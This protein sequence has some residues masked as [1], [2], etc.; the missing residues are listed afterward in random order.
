VQ[1]LL[2]VAPAPIDVPATVRAEQE[3]DILVQCAHHSNSHIRLIGVTPCS[4]DRIRATAHADIVHLA[5][6]AT[7]QAVELEDDGGSA[8]VIGSIEAASALASPGPRLL[9]LNGCDTLELGH[10][11]KE[12]LHDAHV[13][14]C[15]GFLPDQVAELFTQTFYTALL[16]G[17]PVPSCVQ[18]AKA[19]IESRLQFTGFLYLEG[20]EWR[21]SG[22]VGTIHDSFVRARS[23]LA[24]ARILG[25]GEA[26]RTISSEIATGERSQ[27]VVVGPPRSGVTS[28]I[29]AA[30]V[31]YGHNFQAVQ[32]ASRPVIGVPAA[33]ARALVVVDDAHL[34]D[35][36]ELSELLGRYRQQQSRSVILVGSHWPIR[37]EGPRVLC[38]ESIDPA[39]SRSI[40]EREL[41]LREDT[42]SLITNEAPPLPGYVKAIGL[43]LARGESADTALGGVLAEMRGDVRSLLER[44]RARDVSSYAYDALA[45]LGPTLPVDLWDYICESAA[46]ASGE[47]LTMFQAAGLVSIHETDH[48]RRHILLIS[49]LGSEPA[50]ETAL[51]VVRRSL[52]FAESH[53]NELRVTRDGDWLAKL[54]RVGSRIGEGQRVARLA[55]RLLAP[56]SPFR[57]AGSGALA[58]P[59][60]EAGFAAARALGEVELIAQL[61]LVLG[62]SLY[63]A[64]DVDGANAV[65][66]QCADLELAPP[67]AIRVL[68]A[69]GQVQY[70]RGDFIGAVQLYDR[71]EAHR[72]D[73]P[74]EYGVTLDSQ[75]AKAMRRLGDVDGAL[76]LQQQ[77][78]RFYR[79]QGEPHA[80]AKAQHEMARTLAEVGRLAE[81]EQAFQAAVLTAE[82]EA[83]DRFLP[84]PLYELCKLKLAS[85]EIDDAAAFAARL[86]AKAPRSGDPL[87][88]AYARFAEGR[89]AFARRR[90]DRSRQAVAEA[91]RVADLGGYVQV[92]ADVLKWL[93]LASAEHP[94]VA[95]ALSQTDI[96]AIAELTGLPATKA[97]KAWAYALD[98]QRVTKIVATFRS[99]SAVRT[100]ALEHGAWRCDCELF[101]THGNCS[102]VAAMRLG[103]LG[104]R[105]SRA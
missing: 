54:L 79:E 55:A 90:W 89:I 76:R 86:A 78:V 12:L 49:D 91:V 41:S 44:V 34:W 95:P 77:A 2:Y 20:S 71:A 103:V 101:S 3:A 7:P 6:H 35:V 97:A 104:A 72:S 93:A 17:R 8:E 19:R 26:L 30:I 92:R 9:V 66:M 14:A 98:T 80:M 65:F 70:R 43:R 10:R 45:L 85:G 60:A 83:L 68:R 105:L 47:L 40:L 16:S 33:P 28:V 39:T 64:G 67:D 22:G 82:V 52:E 21:L 5:A 42:A 102:H 75:R 18:H 46:P 29:Q 58:R 24:S 84:A 56:G 63:K 31:R 53:A 81:A 11:A 27:I 94:D 74:A 69:L 15:E 1:D 4:L 37:L 99:D 36:D 96:D 100:L 32:H 88:T 62:E 57:Y 50:L 23:R 73:A 48:Q 13:I 25:R 61:G 59:V 51:A 38:L 87:W